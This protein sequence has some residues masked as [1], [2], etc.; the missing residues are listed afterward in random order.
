M[1]RKKTILVS[2]VKLVGYNII[3]K[4]S[5]PALRSIQNVDWNG[6]RNDSAAPKRR[7]TIT[8]SRSKTRHSQT[9]KPRNSLAPNSNNARNSLA[10]SGGN[11]TRNSLA[12]SSRHSLAPNSSAA[13]RQSLSMRRQ[14]SMGVKPND[15]KKQMDTNIRKIIQYLSENNYP[16]HVSLKMLQQPTIKDFHDITIFLFR[17]IDAG[18]E[19]S[20]A[21]EEEIPKFFK[22]IHCPYTLNRSSLRAVS[23]IATW[24]TVLQA[25][26]WLVDCLNYQK[27]EQEMKVQS[28]DDFHQKLFFDFLSLTYQQFLQGKNTYEE[29]EAELAE[30]FKQ[31]NEKVK[32]SIS[33]INHENEKLLTEIQKLKAEN[34]QLPVMKD[35]LTDLSADARKFKTMVDNWENHKQQLVERNEMLSS[36]LSEANEQ[37]EEVQNEQQ[38]VLAKLDKQEMKSEDV[39]RLYSDRQQLQQELQLV[40]KHHQSLQTQSSELEQQLQTL[41]ETVQ[42]SIRQYNQLATNMKL[43]P[44]TAKYANGYN[45][46]INLRP[47]NLHD[48]TFHIEIKKDIKLN[49]M[50]LREIFKHKMIEYDEKRIQLQHIQEQEIE[51]LQ[52]K[53][54]EAEEFHREMEELTNQA[55]VKKQHTIEEFQKLQTDVNKLREKSQQLEKTSQEEL[56]DAIQNYQRVAKQHEKAQNEMLAHRDNQVAKYH[57]TCTKIVEHKEYLKG[58]LERMFNTVKRDLYCLE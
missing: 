25:L 9:S 22:Q 56:A 46:E 24:P 38:A 41:F 36:K 17:E 47:R 44:S 26:G 12:P 51:K 54:E 18:F 5:R 16:G 40:M 28:E 20:N 27:L 35:K 49:I 15:A 39:Q 8:N 55:E 34:E 37:R 33:D 43:I 29:L 52:E 30:F 1:A 23:S 6:G 32:E 4:M 57:E 3:F 42:P 10:P 48:E 2:F 58:R 7:Q 53:K 13:S 21:P 19:W 50:K 31:R 14:S 45:F 11:N